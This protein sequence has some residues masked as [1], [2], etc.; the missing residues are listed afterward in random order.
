[1]EIADW[2]RQE[3]VGEW[4]SSSSIP[5][6][7]QCSNSY[8]IRRFTIGTCFRPVAYIVLRILVVVRRVHYYAPAATNHPSNERYVRGFHDHIHRISHTMVANNPQNS[9]PKQNGSVV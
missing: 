9:H 7:Q 3:M 5:A 2:L 4:R 8:I 1:M 6:A